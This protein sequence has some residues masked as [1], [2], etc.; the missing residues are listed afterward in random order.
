[1]DKTSLGDRMKR[2]EGI[3]N[4]VVVPR[5]PIILRVDG[6]AFHNWV[7]KINAEKPF[8]QRLL[9][10][11]GDTAIELC[12]EIQGA[13]FAYQQSDEISI[14]IHPYQNLESQPWFGG[15][16]QK[17]VSISAATAS[18]FMSLRFGIKTIFDSRVFVLPENEVINYFI[19]RQQDASRN[20]VQM[21]ARSKFSHKAC[22]NKSCNELQE[23]L[24]QEHNLNWND[25]PPVQ[26]R[27]LGILRRDGK[28]DKDFDIPIF[29]QDRDYIKNLFFQ[30]T[31]E[32]K[33]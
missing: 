9:D 13:V 23:M 29:T 19:W 4:P 16:L 22:N 26:K 33:E 1:M 2:F 7:K 32:V 12:Q 31:E 8:D 25:L 5:M 17:M 28:W 20:S 18:S 21:V 14:L 24:W 10:A 30:K 6:K 15:K 11:M 27:G 3:T